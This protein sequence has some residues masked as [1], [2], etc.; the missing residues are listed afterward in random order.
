M[1]RSKADPLRC[2]AV[3]VYFGPVHAVRAADLAVEA[4]EVVALLGPS[5]C[6]KTT[7]LRTIAGFQSVSAGEIRLGD[8]VIESR[9]RSVPAHRRSVGLVFQDFALFPHKTVAENI[10]Y[11]LP[12]GEDAAARVAELLSLAGLDGYGPRYPH[13][14]SA[15]QQQRVVIARAL[16]LKPRFVVCDEPVSALDVS[17]QAQ[18]VNLLARMQREFQVAYLFISHDLKIVRHISHRVAVMY[19]GQIV[20][21]APREELFERPLHPYTQALIAAVPVPDPTVK[22]KRLVLH[23]EP[24]SPVHPPPGCRFHTRCPLAEV[25]CRSEAPVLRTVASGHQVSCHLV[26]GPGASEPEITRCSS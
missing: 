11:G 12:R 16:I 18:V 19:L 17:V 8:E 4:G 9:E 6:G 25:R 3:D 7:L 24:P 22:R 2:T 23:G 26:T 21:S 20:E 1:T 10:G 15:G 14:L 13:Q 5:G